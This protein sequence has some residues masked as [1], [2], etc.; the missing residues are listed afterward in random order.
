MDSECC[1]RLLRWINLKKRDSK[2]NF[3]QIR[4]CEDQVRCAIICE[5]RKIK[6]RLP[7]RISIFNTGA[8]AILKAVKTTRIILTDSLSNLMAQEKIYTRVNNKR[9]RPKWCSGYDYRLLT[10]RFRVRIP[11]KVWFFR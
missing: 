7:K 6:I 2:L 8:V 1:T 9:N 5:V 4:R 3:F 10:Q 11:G